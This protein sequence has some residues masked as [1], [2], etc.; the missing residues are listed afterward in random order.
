MQAT[1]SSDAT[2]KMWD[3]VTGS[4]FDTLQ[5]HTSDLA[6]VAFSPSASQLVTVGVDGNVW[7]MNVRSGKSNPAIPAHAKSINDGCYSVDGSVFATASDDGTVAVWD[8]AGENGL[9]STVSLIL[10]TIHACLSRG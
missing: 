10:A 8:A 5:E 3:P 9:I 1:A 4:C 7:G 2:V 6:L